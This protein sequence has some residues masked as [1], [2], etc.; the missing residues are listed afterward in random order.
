MNNSEIDQEQ[1]EVWRNK[2]AERLIDM[3]AFDTIKGQRRDVILTAWFL[4]GFSP[5]KIADMLNRRYKAAAK[6]EK[7]DG[8][9]PKKRPAQLKKAGVS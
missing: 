6:P 3:K 7:K 5:K 8:D 4:R 2:I 9:R 1:L